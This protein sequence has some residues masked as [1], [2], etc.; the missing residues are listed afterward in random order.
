MTSNFSVLQR[1]LYAALGNG[2]V[3]AEYWN[4]KSVV[5]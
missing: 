1:R 4:W 3:H 2:K 5:D